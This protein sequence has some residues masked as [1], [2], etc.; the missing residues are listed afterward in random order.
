MPAIFINDVAHDL[1]NPQ[2]TWG[3]LLVA[4][5]ERAAGEGLLLTGARFDGVDEPAFRAPDVTARPLSEVTRVD[6][7]TASPGAF[8]RQ[9]LLEALQPLQNAADRAQTLSSIYRQHDV[10]SAHDGLTTLAGELRGLTVLIGMLNG[11]LGI[12]LASI[13]SDG[14]SAEE[15]VEE[16]G[17]L[18]DSLVAAQESEDWVTVADILE[19]DLS[20]AIQNWV[21]LLQRLREV[22]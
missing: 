12:D 16:L 6:V 7:E 10:S 14:V 13:A 4:L 5:E 15:R 21:G 2:Q 8:L 9:C 18:I 20:P 17:A 3:D 19:F 22:M 11:P 1:E